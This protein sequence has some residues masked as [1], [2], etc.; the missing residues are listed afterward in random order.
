MVRT[1]SSITEH[2]TK[3]STKTLVYVL[4]QLCFLKSKLTILGLDTTL[5]SHSQVLKRRVTQTLRWANG[6]ENGTASNPNR[7]TSMRSYPFVVTWSVCVLL[8]CEFSKLFETNVVLVENKTR[9]GHIVGERTDI[10]QRSRPVLPNVSN[11]NQQK[12]WLQSKPLVFENVYKHNFLF[13]ERFGTISAILPYHTPNPPVH[14]STKRYW[15]DHAR[16]TACIQEPNSQSCFENCTCSFCKAFETGQCLFVAIKW[17]G[18]L[19]SRV[20]RGCS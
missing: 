14:T 17:K 15:R 4:F 10:P 3:F 7:H 16:L 20:A 18:V 2:V 5:S 19:F 1:N 9:N 13:R 11:W 8:N 6:N 12:H